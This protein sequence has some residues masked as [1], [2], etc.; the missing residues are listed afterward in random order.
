[1]KKLDLSEQTFGSLT[2]I[3]RAD[4]IGRSA[5]LCRCVCGKEVRCTTG[6]LRQKRGT[7]C[8]C[9]MRLGASR[10]MTTHG[11]ARTSEYKTWTGIKTRC[12]NAKAKSFKAY[13]GRGI[14][15][16][17]V[18]LSFETFISDMGPMPA[19]GYTIE[20]V[21]NERG[22]GPGNCRWAT[23][24]EQALNKRTTRFLTLNDVRLPMA[25]WARKTGIPEATIERRINAR[26][27]SEEK[28]LSTPVIH[29]GRWPKR[30]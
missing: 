4:G 13:G 17:D 15:I 10:R 28:A 2:V 1:M 6:N 3:K 7:A 16:A 24:A 29:T 12:T 22:Y 26:G 14:T 25:E 5:W 21:D 11:L 8:R 23:S 27:W 19:P 18:W 9:K 30:T 20:R